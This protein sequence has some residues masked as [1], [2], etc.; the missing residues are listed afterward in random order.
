M[1][2]RPPAEGGP[3]HPA[4]ELKFLA[5]GG[6]FIGLPENLHVLRRDCTFISQDCEHNSHL[7]AMRGP[8]RVVRCL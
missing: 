7:G 4:G 5:L 2:R 1:L 6:L 8:S 3:T